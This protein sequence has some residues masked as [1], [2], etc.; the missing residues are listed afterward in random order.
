MRVFKH[1]LAVSG[2]TGT[3]ATLAFA[4][5][6]GAAGIDRLKGDCVVSGVVKV[7]PPI[8]FVGGTGVYTFTGT[9]TCIGTETSKGTSVATF[10]SNVDV[11]SP[12]SYTNIVCGTGKAVSTPNGLTVTG[13]TVLSLVGSPKT[14]TLAEWQAIAADLD[15]AV[16]FY[17]FEGQLKWTDRRAQKFSPDV[18]KEL[19]PGPSGYP[20]GWVK[21]LPDPAKGSV[22]PG[23]CT[24][25]F[26]VE[27]TLDVDW[28]PSNPIV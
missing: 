11:N 16:E 3:I 27:A 1:L 14:D 20:G 21:L 18:P 4:A 26:Q 17:D 15:Y 9:A 22:L 12:G 6:A 2:L 7:N 25:A 24:K 19:T 5:P 28:S 8:P 13:V 23:A 10:L